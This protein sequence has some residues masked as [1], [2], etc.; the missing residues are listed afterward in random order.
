MLLAPRAALLALA[1]TLAGCSGGASIGEACDRHNDCEDSLQ[2]VRH[3]CE[4]RCERA[5]DCGDGY[6]CEELVRCV[7]SQLQSGD[8]CASEVECAPGLTCRIDADGSRLVKRCA[9][10]RGTAAAGGACIVDADCRNGTCALGR[11]V[12]LCRRN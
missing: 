8:S 4:P 12:D 11:C 3:V 2:C 6:S 7:L 5:P 1:V 9:P 10:Q